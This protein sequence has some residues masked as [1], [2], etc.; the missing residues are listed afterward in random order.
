MQPSVADVARSGDEPSCFVGRMAVAGGAEGE[1]R[2]WEDIVAL[3][4]QARARRQAADL[5][6]RRKR[7]GAA[8]SRT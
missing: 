8:G 1:V 3:S 4:W 7:D 6:A 2:G 5:A